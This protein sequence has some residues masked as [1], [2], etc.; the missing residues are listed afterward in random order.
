[1]ESKILR[2]S[3]H[4]L[5]ELQNSYKTGFA[6][7]FIS[8]QHRNL[9]TVINYNNR[10]NYKTSCQNVTFLSV[11]QNKR[12]IHDYGYESVLNSTIHEM[13][14]NP[15]ARLFN[16]EDHSGNMENYHFLQSK[17]RRY[18]EMCTVINKLKHT[19]K[20]VFTF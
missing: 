2:I 18:D 19:V 10:R 16:E 14:D 6:N 4:W 12:L 1:M 20:S 7:Q 3:P 8:I 11:E 17:W 13:L 9:S 15:R 5:N